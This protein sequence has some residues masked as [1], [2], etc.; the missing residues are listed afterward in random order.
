MPTTAEVFTGGKGYFKDDI[1]NKVVQQLNES[2]N[3]FQV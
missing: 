2:R 1:M 3:L